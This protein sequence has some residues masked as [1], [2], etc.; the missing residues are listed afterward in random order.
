[1]TQ[2]YSLFGLDPNKKSAFSIEKIY[3]LLI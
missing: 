3:R 2:M 1:M